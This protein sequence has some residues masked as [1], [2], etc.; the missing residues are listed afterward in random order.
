MPQLDNAGEQW[1][2][3]VVQPAQSRPETSDGWPDLYPR[4][5]TGQADHQAQPLV[6]VPALDGQRPGSERPHNYDA[7]LEGQTYRQV[8]GPLKPLLPS[9][10]SGAIST[11]RVPPRRLVDR[12]DPRSLA[13]YQ[14]AA[15]WLNNPFA[16]KTLRQVLGTAVDDIAWRLPDLSSPI[17]RLRR[18]AHA[19]VIAG[20]AVMRTQLAS[21]GD[22]LRWTRAVIPTY[23]EHAREALRAAK[24]G[25]SHIDLGV[26]RNAVQVAW[27]RGQSERTRASVRYNM[28]RTRVGDTSPANRNQSHRNIQHSRAALDEYRPAARRLVTSIQRDPRYAG[29]VEHFGVPQR[30]EEIVAR[31]LTQVGPAAY[32]NGL[33]EPEG[34]GALRQ[35]V[36]RSLVYIATQGNPRPR[37]QR[38]R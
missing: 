38:H 13:T 33:Y 16:D 3:P 5:S 30:A 14:R 9:D 36:V 24:P 17:E 34:R 35:D 1:H 2:L 4:S 12:D 22:T 26:A 21:V 19:S 29:L 6:W 25:I 32:I 31:G 15:A 7:P 18:Q 27:Q 23:A 10:E 8:I 28:R 11:F 37:Q 20:A